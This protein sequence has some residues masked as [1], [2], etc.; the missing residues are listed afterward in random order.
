MQSKSESEIEKAAVRRKYT[1]YNSVQQSR[2]EAQHT[3]IKG[4]TR[5]IALP[6]LRCDVSDV[7]EHKRIWLWLC[8]LKRVPLYCA[9]LCCAVHRVR[10][11]RNVWN[12][13]SS[14]NFGN[15][16]DDCATKQD[17]PRSFTYSAAKRVSRPLSPNCSDQ[18]LRYGV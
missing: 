9:M 14:P 6:G 13:G 8:P 3:E 10:R 18:R 5:R 11:V 2:A 17:I 4:R 1:L 15:H 7:V 16:T 12:T